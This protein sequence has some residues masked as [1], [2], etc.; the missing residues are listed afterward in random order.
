MTEKAAEKEVTGVL[1]AWVARSDFEAVPEA[2]K[3]EAVRTLLNWIGC[4]VGGSDHAS[5]GVAL[6]ALGPFMGPGSASLLGRKEK[7]DALHAAFLNG[8]GSHVFDF[9]D[10]HL[11]TIIHPAGPVA[12]AV[13]ALAEHRPVS[14]SDFLHALILGIEAECRIGNAVY[15]DHYDVGWHITGTAGVFGAAAGAGR[16][17]GL[18]RQRMVWALGIAATQAAGLREMFG[19]MCKG[20]HVGRAAQNGLAAALL[21]SE[22]FTSSEQ[23]I[24][25]PRGFARVLSTKRD[26]SE[27][28]EGL[29]ERYEI[30]LN[31]YKPFPCGIVIHPTIDGCLQIR[32]EQGLKGDE[33][34]GVELRVHPLVLELTGKTNPRTG[35]EG[36]FSVYH[37]AAVALL[38]GRAGLAEFSD[39]AVNDPAVIALRDRVSASV[40]EGL[41]EAEALVVVR[42][43]DG[44][45]IENRVEHAIGSLERPLSD[46]AL[47]QKVHDLA[48]PILGKSGV[49]ALIRICRDVAGLP[50]A[51]EL[52]RAATP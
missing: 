41:K 43:K 20:F 44:Q 35:L 2:V 34:E 48:D 21:A 6:R 24:E 1:A 49:K 7:V 12:S 13:L 14:G 27:I 22:G 31:T 46:Q 26:Y 4:A 40:G 28:T 29:G 9:D 50:D 10:T 32:E 51:A 8:I 18:D 5:V 23:A 11:K 30:L 47:D 25:A 39:E 36:K 17:L 3:R 42:L 15:P 33:I 37:A 38:R 16:L 19:S 45:R 52:A